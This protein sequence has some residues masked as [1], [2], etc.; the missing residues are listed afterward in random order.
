MLRT[1]ESSP[2]RDDG[3][4]IWYL[5]AAGSG[6]YFVYAAVGGTV[7]EFYFR[8]T[9]AGPPDSR[10]EARMGQPARLTKRSEYGS[11]SS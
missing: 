8:L 5:T 2:A 9:R 10:S 1:I 4:V 6:C 7:R 11:L 3:Y